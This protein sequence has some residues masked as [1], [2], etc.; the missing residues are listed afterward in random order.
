MAQEEPGELQLLPGS[1]RI[2]TEIGEARA[3][4]AVKLSRVEKTNGRRTENRGVE[5]A[6]AH[7]LRVHE[8]LVE[9][10]DGRGRSLRPGPRAVGVEDDD[11]RVERRSQPGRGSDK[12]QR[13]AAPRGRISG[14]DHGRVIASGSPP[15]N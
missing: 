3:K 7:R 9:I 2:K 13:E 11:E 6:A 10:H 15:V 8:A 1:A 12:A 14:P 5:A 4:P